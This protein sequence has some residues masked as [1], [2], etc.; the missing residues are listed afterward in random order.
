LELSFYDLGEEERE[1][2][3]KFGDVMQYLKQRFNLI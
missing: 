3:D 2:F 1:S